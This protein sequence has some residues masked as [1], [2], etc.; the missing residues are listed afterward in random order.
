MAVYKDG[1]RWRVVFRYTNWKGER[2]QTSKRGFETKKEAVAWE[3]EELL[4]L[5]VK[6]DMSFERFFQLY[7][8]D[9]TK[10]VKK[11][12]EKKRS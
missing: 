1:N 10:R 4:K 12:S 6:M 3:R 7:E 11:S 9:K 2:K 8:Q 5:N